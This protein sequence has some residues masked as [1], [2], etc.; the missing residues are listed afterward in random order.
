MKVRVSF[1]SLSSLN[2]LSSLA[3]VAAGVLMTGPAWS[4][5]IPIPS[6]KL[7]LPVSSLPDVPLPG[8]GA[9]IQLDLDSTSIS[10]EILGGR[11]LDIDLTVPPGF[12]LREV[13]CPAGVNVSVNGTASVAGSGTGLADCVLSIVDVASASA[14][15]VPVIL[16]RN[17]FLLSV[18]LGLSQQLDRF[19][20]ESSSDNPFQKP[21][22][23]GAAPA[24]GDWSGGE[25]MGL[26]SSGSSAPSN[27]AFSTS[28]QQTQRAAP[29]MLGANPHATE[30]AV[31]RSFNIWT[32]GYLAHT[33]SDFG[34]GESDGHTAV[35]YAGADYLLSP[36][37][38]LGALVQYDDQDRKFDGAPLKYGE[39]GWLAGPYAVLRLSDTVFFQ[40]RAAWGQSE[41]NMRFDGV[42]DD[43]FDSN[44]WLVKGRLLANLRSGSWLVRPSASIAY[45]EDHLEAYRS[46]SGIDIAGRTLS[47]GQLKFGP[48]IAYSF[49][50]TAGISLTP[51]LTIEGIW[52]FEQD[53]GAAGFDDFAVADGLRGRVEAGATIQTA[54]GVSLGVA[55]SYDGI[56]ISDF[57]AVG[58]RAR[59]NVPLN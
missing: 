34:G 43:S 58:G 47:L 12:V 55:A 37:L 11:V 41:N 44:R 30:R 13:S 40:T 49:A 56:G 36:Y 3:A 32:E 59:L 15:A 51:S 5:V 42:F 22:G 10:A 7:D 23:L 20:G 26:L 24:T 16:Q 39:N 35:I 53:D 8:V 14:A 52:N 19:G 25:R 48:E 38:L 2:F 18:E 27:F 31:S 4:Q 1:L 28:L 6:V 45:V 29:N 9:Q 17:D 21:S 57:S 46:S 33:E 50:P 54:R